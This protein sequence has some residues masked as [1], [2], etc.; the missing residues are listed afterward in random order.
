MDSARCQSGLRE[1]ESVHQLAHIIDSE[2]RPSL[3]ALIE[4]NHQP[5][6]GCSIG[7][8]ALDDIE[9]RRSVAQYAARQI[10]V[11]NRA[12]EIVQKGTSRI[13]LFISDRP[14]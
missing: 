14:L 1:P 6:L 11:L 9:H 2:F 7:R 4:A 10:E 12:G 8:V 5:F 13:G 3:H